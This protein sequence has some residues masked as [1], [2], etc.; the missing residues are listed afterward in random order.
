MSKKMRADGK[1][2][3]CEPGDVREDAGYTGEN[4][5]GKPMKMM[6]DVATE[7]KKPKAGKAKKK[8]TKGKKTASAELFSGA[9]RREYHRQPLGLK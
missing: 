1:M 8:K 7:T 5:N 9:P 4:G 2:V 3:M 6:D